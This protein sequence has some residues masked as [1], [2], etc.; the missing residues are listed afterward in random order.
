MRAG[1]IDEAP[2]VV[3][4]ARNK[5]AT[6]K[7]RVYNVTPAQQDKLTSMHRTSLRW[8]QTV[9]AALLFI[10]APL[11]AA[12]GEENRQSLMG[13]KGVKVLVEDSESP[14]AIADGL[15]QD[16]LQTDVELRLRK[17]GVT[18]VKD[19][20]AP[21]LYVAINPIKDST[22]LYA[23]S[24]AVELHQKAVISNGM[25][26]YTATRSVST[27]GM[28]GRLNMSKYIREVVGDMV[29]KFLNAY[30]SANPK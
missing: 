27:A 8:L 19:V 23:Y 15:T 26:L 18:I 9:T 22:G 20:G 24:C 2:A 3:R 25:K 30:L 4:C 28:V 5:A 13:I 6:G 12:D 10:A 14:D 11:L 29:D 21:Y 1:F 17:A 16:Q 7:K